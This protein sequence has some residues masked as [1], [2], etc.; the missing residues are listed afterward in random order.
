[1]KWLCSAQNEGAVGEEMPINIHTAVSFSSH[2]ICKPRSLR[3]NTALEREAGREGEHL[4][5][6]PLSFPWHELFNGFPLLRVRGNIICIHLTVTGT[7]WGRGLMERLLM[8]KHNMILPQ[9]SH[10]FNPSCCW[11]HS[12]L[13]VRPHVASAVQLNSRSCRY[14]Y[15]LPLC[16]FVW[17]IVCFMLLFNA[18]WH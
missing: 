13:W 18:Y 8:C 5:M 11:F 16:M 12:W 9:Q 1:M 14:S 2:T 7:T 3:G 10:F 4:S 6:E 15:S 17:I